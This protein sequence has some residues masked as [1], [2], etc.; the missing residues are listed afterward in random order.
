[1]FRNQRKQR[2]VP[3]LDTT[4]TADISFMLLIFFLLVSSMDTD[5]GLARQLPAPENPKEIREAE[6]QKGDLLKINITS[7]NQLLVNGKALP[8]NRLH[9]QVE[10]HVNR[11]GRRHVISIDADPASSYH[12]Y[13]QVQD[14][15][16][17]A[18]KD[19]RNKTAQKKYGRPFAQLS[20]DEKKAVR[21]L[22]PQRIAEVYDHE[23]GGD[24]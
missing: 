12:V 8:A 17:A 23:K 21:D 18:Y 6:V 13:F 7:D 19:V 22:C 14:E 24:Q 11:V 16:A 20:L 4:S 1:M 9:Q 5:K 3:G 2:S 15:I 10:E